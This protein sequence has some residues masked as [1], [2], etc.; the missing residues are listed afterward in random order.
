[1][2][3]ITLGDLNSFV[4]LLSG[5]EANEITIRLA[6]RYTGKFKI[7][8]ASRSYHGGTSAALGAT[9]DFRTRFVGEQP[10]FVRTLTHSASRMAKRTRRPPPR[11]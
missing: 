3:E 8:T 2:A 1:M 10:G 4:F 5:S 9:G 7:L 11:V 6:R